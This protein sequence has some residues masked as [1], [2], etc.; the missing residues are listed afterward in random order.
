MITITIE[1][2]L[3]IPKIGSYDPDQIKAR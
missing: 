3:F 1:R 2:G